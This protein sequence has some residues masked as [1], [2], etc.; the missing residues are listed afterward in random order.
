MRFLSL[1]LDSLAENLALDEALLDAHE[2]RKIAGGVL[3]LWE[4]PS[5][6]IVLGRSSKAHVEVNLDTCRQNHIGVLRR[7]SGGGTIVAGPGC[8]MYAVVLDFASYP[9]LRAVDLA[10]HFVLERLTKALSP[11]VPTVAKAGISDLILGPNPT[12]KTARKF[13]GNA[14]RI[15]RHHLLY[16]GT[17]LY[18]FDL[19]QISR[20]LGPTTRQPAYRD[21]RTH[22]EFIINLPVSRAD[23]EQSLVTVWDA[24]QPLTSWPQT[25]VAEIIQTKYV[26]DPKWIISNPSDS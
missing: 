20:L 18:N 13:S 3:R 6:G 9:Q 10:H 8:L 16:H 23:I 7:S 4:A 25:R 22:E 5:H 26:N 1:T 15:K 24:N 21:R 12:G 17:L 2:A 11:F 19:S 14:L